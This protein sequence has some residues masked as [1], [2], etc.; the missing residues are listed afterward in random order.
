MSA[1][2]F[3]CLKKTG[4]A[5]AISAL[6]ENFGSGRLLSPDGERAHQPLNPRRTPPV[7]SRI[8]GH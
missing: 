3:Q 8:E 7:P 5:S 4:C 2:D 1:C 6:S